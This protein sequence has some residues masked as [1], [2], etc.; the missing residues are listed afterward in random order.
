MTINVFL[1]LMSNLMLNLMSKNPQRI[2]KEDKK[3]GQ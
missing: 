2:T 1:N 3:I